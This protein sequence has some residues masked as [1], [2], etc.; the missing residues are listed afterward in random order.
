LVQADA[1]IYVDPGLI[2]TV[3]NL[4]NVIIQANEG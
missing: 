3:D 1:T 2:A 4:G